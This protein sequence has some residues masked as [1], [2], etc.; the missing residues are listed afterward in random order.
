MQK[1]ICPN[2][3][4]ELSKKNYPIQEI[5]SSGFIA[6][7]VSAKIEFNTEEKNLKQSYCK[8]C[9]WHDT[10]VNNLEK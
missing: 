1:K 5:K 4:K 10:N 6:G 2:C 3:G 8:N 7:D 9:N